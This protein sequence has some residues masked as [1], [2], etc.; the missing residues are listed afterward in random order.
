M[1]RP[2]AKQSGTGQQVTIPWLLNDNG[3]DLCMMYLSW[4]GS[5]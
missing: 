4:L 2:W 1:K 3:D 5:S